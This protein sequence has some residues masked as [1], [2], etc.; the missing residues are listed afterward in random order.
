MI[1]F[2]EELEDIVPEKAYQATRY[3]CTNEK[4]GKV[5]E[6]KTQILTEVSKAATL[7]LEFIDDI[8]CETAYDELSQ[9]VYDANNILDTLEGEE[10]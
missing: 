10:K 7:M 4:C 9:V 8:A 1:C 2:H 5:F 6:Y 3:K